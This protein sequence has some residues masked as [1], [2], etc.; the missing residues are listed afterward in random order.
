MKTAFLNKP[1]SNTYRAEFLRPSRI[2]WIFMICILTSHF[3]SHAQYA[4]LL[5]FAQL[6]N[7][8]AYPYGALLYD[9][10]FMYGMTQYGG[11]N[12]N[13]TIF[14]VMPDGS[15]YTKLLDFDGAN[16][17]N[18]FGSLIYDGTF[19][20]GMTAQGGANGL[21]VIFKIKPDGAEYSKLLDFEGTN[22][23]T[24]MGSLFAIGTSLFGTTSGGGSG[25]A[26][27]IFK[28]NSDG[29]GYVKLLDFVGI[30]NGSYPRGSLI[31]DG[32]FL[33]GM[34]EGG[35][36]NDIGTIFKIMP[37]GTGY[38][39][40][41]DFNGTANGSGP[42]GD[43]VSDGTFLYGM[44]PAGGSNNMGTIFKIMPDGTGYSKLLDFDGTNGNAPHDALIFDGT[45]LYG[46]TS[47]GGTNGG[48]T[49]FKIMP[50]GTG[51]AK[52]KQLD[53]ASP[54]AS[55]VSDGTFLYG[56]T[57]NGGGPGQGMIFKIKP[58]GTEFARTFAFYD[59]NGGYPRGSLI[60]D[61]TFLYGTT[62]T[63]GKNNHG[64]IFKVRPD[65]T[66]PGKIH[67]FV[68]NSESYPHGSLISD[69]T[70]LYGMTLGYEVTD[71]GTVFKIMPDGTGYEV[72]LNFDGA[73]S[74]HPYGSLF[75]DGTFLYGMTSEGGVF[76]AGSIF[77]VMPDG[78]GY[79]LL[80]DFGDGSDGGYPQGSLIADGEF[81]YGM[82]GG[83]GANGGGTIFKIRPDGTG[84]TKLLDFDNSTGMRPH[85]DLLSD[86]TFL[87]G[88]TSQGGTNND[89]TIFKIGLDGMGFLKLL[90]FDSNVIGGDPYGSLIFE[91]EFLYG[92]TNG[93][94]DISSI[95]KIRPDGTGFE[96]LLTFSDAPNGSLLSDG[97]YLYGLT[98]FGGASSYGT[99]FRYALVT[100]PLTVTLHPSD[101]T[102]CDGTVT[103]FKAEA[104]GTT[105]ITYQW[106]F[107]T[108]STGPFGDL[109]NDGTYSG[110]TTNQLSVTTGDMVG[111]GYYRCKIDGDA[112]GTVFTND[113]ALV[114]LPVPSPPAVTSASG[115]A[116]A[117][118]TLTASGGGNGD[119]RWYTVS[120]GG[121]PLA[122][123]V[124][125]TYTTPLLTT[126]ATYYVSINNGTC[127]GARAAVLAEVVEATTNQ[128]PV[129]TQTSTQTTV[130]GLVIIDLASLVSDPDNNLDFSTLSI[131]VPPVSGAN[132]SIDAQFNLLIDYT[133]VSFS[134][135]DRLTLGICDVLA[136]CTQQEI[137]IEVE[138]DITPFNALSPNGDGKND[139]FFIQYIDLLP[140]TRNNTVT[141]YNRWGDEVFAVQ[142]YD[143]VTHVFRGLSKNG[144]ALPSG[145]YFYKI[146]FSDNN[147]S[148]SGFISL[149]R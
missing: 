105:N 108:T 111:G 19:L 51:Y 126:S 116:P 23:S 135:T 133:G 145:T 64:T 141:I 58:D 43:L 96:N 62:S 73:N 101:T 37:D 71:Y 46:T 12:N 61:G 124:N 131:V 25:S 49:V 34:T 93:D 113:A 147:T 84:F 134:G 86:G 33:Y 65:G 69:G 48:G 20:F 115:V 123:E 6:E 17:S 4:K 76:N 30:T 15:A 14:K 27:T 109:S 54:D 110:V 28:I 70:F 100:S 75:Y 88:M 9:G 78:S 13:G 31:S 53:I 137:T 83:S 144:G 95:F 7:D 85:G 121:T 52:L 143:N 106:Q 68:G 29:T 128:S 80:H 122:G 114:I 18:P 127:E 89:G 63:K 45:F 125:N 94:E 41:L 10:T 55:L 3:Q 82:T 148:M 87:Y 107:A 26:G 104:T 11:I 24:P 42:A 35:G 59:D 136:T 103:T 146:N 72:I 44:T 56:T 5:D 142:N 129:I 118:L 74:A 39:K 102:L 32:T 1:V 16:G 22:G 140:G 60:S 139:F 119:Y 40:L 138:G 50:D 77:K 21:G 132:A 67:D 117:S 47:L 92:M 120:A 112:A 90:D 99:M 8:A 2:G 91:G 57:W 149:K 79:V 97:S 38:L 81:L 98:Q 130:E 66:D 36:A